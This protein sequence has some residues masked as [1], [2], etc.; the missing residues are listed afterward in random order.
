MG[1]LN[2]RKRGANVFI[3]QAVMQTVTETYTLE[4]LMSSRVAEAVRYLEK[5]QNMRM[6]FPK[7]KT[8]IKTLSH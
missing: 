6:L 1:G 7:F 8:Q 4:C 5:E 3:F 2:A